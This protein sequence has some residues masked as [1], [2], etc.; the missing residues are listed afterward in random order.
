MPFLNALF[1][2]MLLFT[3]P[4]VQADSQLKLQPLQ[5]LVKESFTSLTPDPKNPDVLYGITPVNSLYIPQGG[6][7]YKSTDRGVH[8]TLLV[9]NGGFSQLVIDPFNSDVFYAMQG[10]SDYDHPIDQLD[11]VLKSVDGGKTWSLLLTDNINLFTPVYNSVKLF[12]SPLSQNTVYAFLYNK[13]YHSNDG[14]NS[15]KEIT[16]PA[17]KVVDIAL[18]P[19]DPQGLFSITQDNQLFKSNDA[20]LTWQELQHNIVLDTQDETYWINGT[21]KSLRISPKQANVLYLDISRGYY[22][23]SKYPPPVDAKFLKSSQPNETVIETYKSSDAGQTWQ[24]IPKPQVTACQATLPTCYTGL[25]YVDPYHQDVLYSV[26]NLYAYNS[27]GSKSSEYSSVLYRSQD[28]GNTWGEILPITEGILRAVLSHPQKQDT[29]YVSVVGRTYK[30]LSSGQLLL[31]ENAGKTWTDLDSTFKAPVSFNLYALNP[32]NHPSNPKI[33]YV[34]GENYTIYQTVDGGQTFTAL[35]SFTAGLSNYLTETIEP[36]IAVT[37]NAVFG[38]KYRWMNQ[39]W[40]LYLKDILDSHTNNGSKVQFVGSDIYLTVSETGSSITG[41]YY[42]RSRDN[43]VTWS[44]LNSG[45]PLP[46]AS[47]IV[48]HP[49][50]KNVLYLSIGNLRALPTNQAQPGVYQSVD[51]GETWHDISGDL[52]INYGQPSPYQLIPHPTQSQTLYFSYDGYIHKTVDNGKTWKVVGE[53]IISREKFKLWFDPN[54]SQ[55]MYAMLTRTDIPLFLYKSTDAGETWRN[56]SFDLQD[57][58][59]YTITYEALRFAPNSGK[60][61]YIAKAKERTY[62]SEDGEHWEVITDAARLERESPT[63]MLLSFSLPDMTFKGVYRVENIGNAVSASQSKL[64]QGDTNYYLT[65]SPDIIKVQVVEHADQS[66]VNLKRTEAVTVQAKFEINNI[67][68]YEQPAAFFVVARYQPLDSSDA[69]WFMQ[70]LDKQWQ[71]W[72][73]N[74]ENLKP[75][76]LVSQ[77]K[78]TESLDIFTGTPDGVARTTSIYAGYRPAHTLTSVSNQNSPLVLKI[79]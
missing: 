34:M 68:A 29:V 58:N 3:S 52:P 16:L 23:L 78:P 65:S 53:G 42:Y 69:Y 62:Q 48:V 70:T 61:I 41:V 37:E 35:P 57:T 15:W 1:L 25:F 17:P 77:L 14:G 47:Q 76:K 44:P 74:I 33:F 7:L 66:A 72:D 12:L 10:M 32:I 51:D 13:L 59:S 45:A 56:V 26:A 4:L 24:I 50:Q 79:E 22:A 6:H 11:R 31:S 8:W 49:T 43:A 20:G 2:I 40:Q 30:Q 55:T 39:Q 64:Y 28:G 9:F 21:F 46:Y 67:T 75:A 63:G 19:N 71:M 5:T 27:Y 18:S 60:I 54:N 36:V 73:G 38:Y